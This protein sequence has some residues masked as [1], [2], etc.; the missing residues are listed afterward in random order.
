[1]LRFMLTPRSTMEEQLKKQ[2]REL[3]DDIKN[4]NTKVKGTEDGIMT[5]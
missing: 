4:L 5:F 3:A 2:E 1:M